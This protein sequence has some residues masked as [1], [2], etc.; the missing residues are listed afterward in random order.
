MNSEFLPAWQ[1]YEWRWKIPNFP[2]PERLF[3]QPKWQGEALC[4]QK[5]LVHSEQGFG[6]TI[7][8]ARFTDILAKK[9]GRVTIECQPELKELLKSAPGVIET[10]ARG[11]KLPEFDVHTP[12][13][14]IPGI[15]ALEKDEIPNDTPYLLAP[16]DKRKYWSTKLTPGNRL[17]IGVTWKTGDKQ[18]SA[19]FKSCPLKAYEPL[20]KIDQVDWISLQKVIP[21][22]DQ[23]ISK[24]LKDTSG[25]LKNFADTAAIISELDLII[26][27]DTAVAHL[28]GA[29]GKPIWLLLSTAGDWRWLKNVSDRPWYP[30]MKIFRQ[31]KF[32]DWDGLIRRVLPHIK[33]II[34]KR[35][36]D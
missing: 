11:D 31:T 17:K 3:T 4:G 16:A 29:L 22:I 32:N 28:A 1:E 30:N 36:K 13:L 21:E 10:L 33:E 26:S 18:L 23:P 5:I 6:D 15:L 24:N 20:F 9:G 34:K 35:S 2:T 27:M 14:S 19:S 8:F 25:G 12:L 7:Q